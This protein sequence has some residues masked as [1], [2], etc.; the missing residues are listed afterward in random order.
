MEK[1]QEEIEQEIARTRLPRAGEVLGVII[2]MLGSGRIR[3]ECEDGFTRICRIPG[4]IRK[5][6]W[7][8]AGD[9]VLV[10][11]WKVQTNERADI[12]WRYTHTQASWLKK[13]GYI[14]KIVLE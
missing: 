9:V 11:P 3:A 10:K 4:K 12:A 14:K 8:R 1:T 13:K 5:R 7:M 2:E 6:L